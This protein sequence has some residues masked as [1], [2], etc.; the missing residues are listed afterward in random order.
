MGGDKLRLKAGKETGPRSAQG[1]SGSS[2]AVERRQRRDSHGDGETGRRK[3]PSSA[4]SSRYYGRIPSVAALRLWMDVNAERKQEADSTQRHRGTEKQGKGEA[5][6]AIGL[7]FLLPSVL[8]C[9]LCVSVVNLLLACFLR[10]APFS[11]WQPPCWTLTPVVETGAPW[12]C[13]WALPQRGSKKL[14]QHRDTEARR[15]KAREKQE[16]RSGSSFF[17]ACSSLCPLC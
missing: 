17:S 12:G 6:R 10:I 3:K 14:I 1:R 8:L 5:G 4:S 16:R 7:I 13:G 9:V 2:G 15:S 11:R